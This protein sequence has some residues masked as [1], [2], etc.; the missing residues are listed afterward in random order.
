MCI[1]NYKPTFALPCIL[2]LLTSLKTLQSNQRRTILE[3][4][5]GFLKL[6]QKWS[7]EDKGEVTFQSRQRVPWTSGLRTVVLSFWGL[8]LKKPHLTGE[9]CLFLSQ[10]TSWTFNG[11]SSLYLPWIVFN[12]TAESG[13]PSDLDCLSPGER[14]LSGFKDQLCSLVFT[15]LTDPNTQLQLVGIRT[16]TVLGA[17]PGTL[18][19]KE[20]E[21][22]IG[23][24]LV[25]FCLKWKEV[26]IP[27][28]SLKPW[29]TWD[30]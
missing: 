13:L 27:L 7:Y 28:F 25:I 9:T 29:L 20:K 23:P 14:P 11:L 15:A 5:L 10:C 18:K 3:M 17:Q 8:A 12:I 24:F 19:R 2:G 26:L 30:F 22:G 6:Q 21:R 4:I 16:L 1:H